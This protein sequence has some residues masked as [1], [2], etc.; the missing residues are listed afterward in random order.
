MAKKRGRPP[1]YKPDFIPT[2]QEKQDFSFSLDAIG[3]LSSIQYAVRKDIEDL[4]VEI[5]TEKLNIDK[6][7]IVSA[8]KQLGLEKYTQFKEIQ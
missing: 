8:A 2:I 7:I 3:F 4:A 1:K 5:S 6:K